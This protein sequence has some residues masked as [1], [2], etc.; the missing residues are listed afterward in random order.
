MSAAHEEEERI[1]YECVG[2]VFGVNT[3]NY[4]VDMVEKYWERRKEDLKYLDRENNNAAEQFFEYVSSYL[5]SVGGFSVE[6]FGNNVKKPLVLQYFGLTYDTLR[7]K[8]NG[9]MKFMWRTGWAKE[10]TLDQAAITKIITR[11]LGTAKMKNV[12]VNGE[13]AKGFEVPLG[14]VRKISSL[15]DLYIMALDADK[16]YRRAMGYSGALA[17]DDDSEVPMLTDGT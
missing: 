15:A 2:A 4:V 14:S 3:H 16:R 7:I 9:L 5:E 8:I 17:I 12:R 10:T 6:T 1:C 11:T 13:V